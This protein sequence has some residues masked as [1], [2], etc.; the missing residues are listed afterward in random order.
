MDE[1]LFMVMVPAVGDRFLE[2]FTVNAPPTL[3]DAVGCVE[4]VSDMVRLENV[5]VPELEMVH[6]VVARVMV[7]DEGVNVPVTVSAPFTVAVLLAPVIEPL[8][9][10]LP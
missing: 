5:S 7:P 10:R 8:I 1:P 2:L 9:L 4:G 6:P 3:K